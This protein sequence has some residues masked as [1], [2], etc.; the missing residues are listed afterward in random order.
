MNNGQGGARAA[1]QLSKIAPTTIASPTMTDYENYVSCM[2]RKGTF[3]L[4]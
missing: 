3:L 2:E 4:Q 1:A